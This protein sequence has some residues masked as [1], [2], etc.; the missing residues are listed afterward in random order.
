MNPTTSDLELPLSSTEKS[1]A[2]VLMI[3]AIIISIVIIIMHWPD[4]MPNAENTIYLYKPFRIT[5]IETH[6]PNAQQL[7]A[8]IQAAQD[9]LKEDLKRSDVLAQ[10]KTRAEKAG[11][12][13]NALRAAKEKDSIDIIVAANKKAVNDAVLKKAED[14]KS[15][16][17]KTDCAQ[18]SVLFACKTIQFGVLILILVAASGFLGNMIYVASSFTIFIGAE[19]F[20][21]SWIMWYAVKPFTASGLAILIYLA[22][23]ST[24]INAPINLNGILATAALTGLFTNIATL[25]LKEIFIA[26]FKP[27]VNLPDKL[28]GGKQKIDLDNMHPEKI[29][30]NHVN[31]FLIPG[32]NLDPKN[33]VVSI[34]GIKIAPAKISITP[35][36]I[37]F[38]YE[39]DNNAL[40]KFNLLVTD[41]KGIEIGKKEID[42]V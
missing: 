19:K 29:D 42:V 14:E 9:R 23:N 1:L 30:S 39:V 4:K 40:T 26:P 17:E 28:D 36:L 18:Q 24:T 21:R 13:I 27:S 31:N 41:S 22:L 38:N 6:T 3:F 7:T 34:N 11:D 37:K 20:K 33:I 5:L 8:A 15:K 2:G 25:K 32:Q 10:V 12:S 16:A 35:T